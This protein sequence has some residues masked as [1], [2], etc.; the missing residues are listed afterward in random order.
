MWYCAWRCVRTKENDIK[1]D[2]SSQSSLPQSDLLHLQWKINNILF[3]AGP[4]R[5]C[6]RARIL[7]VPV[8]FRSFRMPLLYEHPTADFGTRP[9]DNWINE[10]TLFIFLN[11]RA[12]P[13]GWG[14]RSVLDRPMTHSPSTNVDKHTLRHH[15]ISLFK[16]LFF[17]LE[18]FI[19][20]ILDR[21]IV[22]IFIPFYKKS[23]LIRWI[24]RIRVKLIKWI[25][26][27]H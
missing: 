10:M 20:I 27:S 25:Q 13:T 1:A 16:R 22:W 6:A 24:I 23:L 12:L 5:V 26:G 15:K 11:K 4:I 14:N 17:Y 9:L 8:H 18:T 21:N 2:V 7:S 19:V 3:I